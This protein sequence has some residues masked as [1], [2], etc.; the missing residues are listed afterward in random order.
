[1]TRKEMKSKRLFKGNE[2]CSC[3]K[4]TFVSMDT[5]LQTIINTSNA[6]KNYTKNK[7]EALQNPEKSNVDSAETFFFEGY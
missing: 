7:N 4:N 3:R 5:R 6:V 2:V 1:M